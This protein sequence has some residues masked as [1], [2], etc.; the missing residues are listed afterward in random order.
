[1]KETVVVRIAFECM[2]ITV[3]GFLS[4][5]LVSLLC[6]NTNRFKLKSKRKI[7]LT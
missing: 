4:R 2:Y 7:L 3:R 5:V 1:M 6:C